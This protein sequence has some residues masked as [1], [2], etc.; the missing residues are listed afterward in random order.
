MNSVFFSLTQ[1]AFSFFEY[2][3]FVVVVGILTTVFYLA[4]YFLFEDFKKVLRQILEKDRL[5]AAWT[6]AC[7]GMFNFSGEIVAEM[8]KKK[9][10]PL[11]E[12]I[13]RAWQ[14]RKIHQEY[15]VNKEKYEW[16]PPC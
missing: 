12:R 15:L 5:D 6:D 1:V 3:V 11:P 13:A 7:G 4:G 2:I 16:K 9:T 8:Q 10:M 14:R